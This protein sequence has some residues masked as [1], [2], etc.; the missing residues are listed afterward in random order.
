VNIGLNNFITSLKP[1]Q[2]VVPLAASNA[3]LFELLKLLHLALIVNPTN[4]LKI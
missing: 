3:E 4:F 1:L 2:S